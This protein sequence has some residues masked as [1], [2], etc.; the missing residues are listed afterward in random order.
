MSGLPDVSKMSISKGMAAVYAPKKKPGNMGTE[1]RFQTNLTRLEVT[2]NLVYYKYDVEMALFFRMPSGSGEINEEKP[3]IFTK[4]PKND[5]DTQRRKGQAT[6]VMQAL[7]KEQAAFFD[8]SNNTLLYDRQAVMFSLREL[9]VPAQ[10]VTF[11]LSSNLVTGKQEAAEIRVKIARVTENFQVSSNDVAKAV[12]IR[13]DQADKGI[14]EVYNLLISQKPFKDQN[15]VTY[16]QCN[17]FMLKAPNGF[18]PDDL[19]PLEECM[20]MK[21]GVS[22]SVKVLEGEG[23][24]PTVYAVTE[25]KKTAI[26]RGNQNLVDKVLSMFNGQGGEVDLRPNSYNAKI[27]EKKIKGLTVALTYGN[28]AQKEPKTFTIGRVNGPAANSRETSF[29]GAGGEKYGS[30]SD[31]LAKKYNVKLRYPQY[32]TVSPK[33]PMRGGN[34]PWFPMELLMVCDLQRVQKEQESVQNQA[35]II[36]CSAALPEKR[37]NQTAAMKR[38]IG[39]VS[40]NK[41]LLNAGIKP[42]DKFTMVKGRVLPQP[43]IAYAGQGNRPTTMQAQA[44]RWRID[45]NRFVKAKVVP[46]W[47]WH[48][49]YGGQPRQSDDLVDDY[50]SKLIREMSDRGVEA[51]EAGVAYHGRVNSNT[52]KAIFEEAKA[53]GIKFL[54]FISE[55]AVKLHDQI[56]LM[57]LEYQV[58]TQ[59]IDYSRMKKTVTN[60]QRD[61]LTNV[62]M[63]I[64]AKCGG[65]NHEMTLHGLKTQTKSPIESPNCLILGFEMSATASEAPCLG[66]AANHGANYQYFKGDY[67][68]CDTKNPE[69]LATC[70]RDICKTVVTEA[71]AAR[72]TA[73]NQLV[74]YLNGPSEGSFKDLITLVTPRIEEAIAPSKQVTIIVASKSHNERIF[75]QQISG[76]NATKQ[77]IPSGTVID[78]HI[79]SPVITEFYMNS[80]LA[81]QGTAKSVKYSVIHDQI[82]YDL[83]TIECLTHLLSFM[84]NI[85]NLATALP[86]PLLVADRCAKRG[87][88]NSIAKY[89]SGSDGPVDFERL[90]STLTYNNK[91]LRQIRFNA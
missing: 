50:Y 83:N 34:R 69:A 75:Q 53:Q 51:T 57:E 58:L 7:T 31:Y 10:G 85:V 27:V 13:P 91:P 63:K 71:T 16:G 29:T 37:F 74:V 21:V 67:R 15:W 86:A 89:G 33:S 14:L 12:N 5:P 80:H 55:T 76:E 24:Q 3:K 30:I 28:D 45:R 25:L 26:H 44:G 41:M 56:K 11:K 59:E 87:R 38:E 1:T 35:I 2:K 18:G 73:I 65:L 90:N 6:N 84:H 48:I 64:N 9:N 68:F 72:K 22:K 49:L 17:H 36:R 20:E 54:F 78:T 47:K 40:D 81:F 46:K 23:K 19:K 42:D 61:T 39:L 82:G 88:N 62:V 8:L 77:N 70:I 43:S 52:V 4:G 79:V 32:F 60:N 66:F